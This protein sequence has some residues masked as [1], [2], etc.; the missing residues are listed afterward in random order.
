MEDCDDQ[1]TILD[2]SQRVLFKEML[3]CLR[4]SMWE[5]LTEYLNCLGSKKIGS[6]Q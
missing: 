4:S 6:C 1:T 3:E 5:L 2:Y